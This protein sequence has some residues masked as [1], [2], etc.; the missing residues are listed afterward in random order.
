MYAAHRT[1]SADGRAPPAPAHASLPRICS[2]TGPPSPHDHR[3]RASKPPRATRH[4]MQTRAGAARSRHGRTAPF[5]AQSERRE[6][7]FPARRLRGGLAPLFRDSAGRPIELQLYR[8]GYGRGSGIEGARALPED[9]RA[10]RPAIGCLRAPCRAPAAHGLLSSGRKPP[11]ATRPS[12]DR[13]ETTSPST[14]RSKT[15]HAARVRTAHRVTALPCTVAI[16]PPDPSAIRALPSADLAP[17]RRHVRRAR[18]S[19]TRSVP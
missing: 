7:A 2:R 10:Q 5:T 12:T 16:D 8:R 9:V 13:A 3:P 4:R 18:A 17:A 15:P 11:R 14:R 6:H 1:R 19:K